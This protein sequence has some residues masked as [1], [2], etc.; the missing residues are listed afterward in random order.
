[1]FAGT[2][3]RYRPA[4]WSADGKW[5]YLFGAGNGRTSILKTAATGGKPAVVAELS[6]TGI[7]VLRISPNGRR[8][9]FPLSEKKTDIWMLEDFEHYH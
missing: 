3:D 6:L 1:V 5:I 9:V 8:F 2:Y 4:G 7:P